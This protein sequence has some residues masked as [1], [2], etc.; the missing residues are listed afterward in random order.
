MRSL[1][2]VPVLLLATSATLFPAELPR[3]GTA[4][5]AERLARI[6]R[7]LWDRDA[8]AVPILREW[9]ASDES[10][11]VRERSIGALATLRDN[12]NPRVY[13]DRLS[14][15]PSPRVRRAAADAI[16]ILAIPVDRADRLSTPLRK[17]PDPM[18]RA[19]CAR[20]IGRTG[21]RQAFPHLL[22]ALGQDSSPEVRA[23][24]AEALM[25]L[26]VAESVEVLR[27]AALQDRSPL[28]RVY[29]VRA[30]VALDPRSS[31]ETFRTVWELATEA[32]LRTAAYEGML[33]TAEAG[34]WIE[35]GLQ[36]KDSHVRY[37]AFHAW[38]SGLK[39]TLPGTR[40]TRNSSEVLRLE[41]FLKDPLRG[42]REGARRSLE[43]LDYRVVEKGNA[44]VIA[45]EE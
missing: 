11:R 23:L 4:T 36:D 37:L 26:K 25:T 6:E 43:N 34:S 27:I 19:E 28:V 31:A 12:R 45:V 5:V 24:C 32:D 14:S 16:G 13:F 30:L 41:T 18:V 9:A 10:D 40:P 38:Q 20:A 44:Y 8:G 42:I 3:E 15:D 35:S 39:S 17:D 33:Q 21:D 22:I 29:A 2:A 1:L 7:I